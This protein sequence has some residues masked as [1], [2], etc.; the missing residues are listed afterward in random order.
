MFEI[1]SGG[2]SGDGFPLPAMKQGETRQDSGVQRNSGIP[3]RDGNT[4]PT[5][6]KVE[7]RKETK[8]DNMENMK[9]P[10]SSPSYP[11]RLEAK[12]LLHIL[13]PER[14]SLNAIRKS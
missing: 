6:R 9:I 14:L 12:A 8:Q 4:K 5:S 2:G 1:A 11:S 3:S 10:S 7:E 13:P